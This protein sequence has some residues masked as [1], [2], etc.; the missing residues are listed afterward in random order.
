MGLIDTD[1]IKAEL[2][3]K[4]CK[5]RLNCRECFDMFGKDVCDIIDDQPMAYDVDKV[6]GELEELRHPYLVTDES[7]GLLHNLDYYIDKSKEI[8]KRGGKDE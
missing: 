8:V 3:E 6:V 2:Q 7:K 5:I 4:Y 1:L